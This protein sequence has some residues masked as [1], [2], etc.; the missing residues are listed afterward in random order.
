MEKPES[1]SLFY[2]DGGSDKEYQASLEEMGAGWIVNYRYGR[3]GSANTAGTKTDGP[4]PYEEAWNVYCKLV[5]SKTDKGYTE[6][7]GDIPF[8]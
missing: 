6:K 4:L 3:R 5:K 8:R 7:N 1:I 2:K